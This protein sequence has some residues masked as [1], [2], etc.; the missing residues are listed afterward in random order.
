M[1]T[2]I[3]LDYMSNDRPD[4]RAQAAVAMGWIRDPIALP[5]LSAMMGDANPLVQVAAAGAI[6]R[7]THP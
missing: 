6:L 4:L 3:V 5:S 2:Q 7:Q 1:P